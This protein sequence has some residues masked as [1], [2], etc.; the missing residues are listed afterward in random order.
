MNT[1]KKKMTITKRKRKLLKKWTFN[2]KKKNFGGTIIFI[3]NKLSSIQ[4]FLSF[5]FRPSY[6]LKTGVEHP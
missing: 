1:R 3:A 6:M 5:A 2:F 4:M